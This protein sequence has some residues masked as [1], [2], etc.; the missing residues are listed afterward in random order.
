[1]TEQRAK[2]QKRRPVS[3]IPDDEIDQ[4]LQVAIQ[5]IGKHL[6]G[7]L[8]FLF[9]RCGRSG[10]SDQ[11]VDATAPATEIGPRRGGRDDGT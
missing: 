1:M 2:Q 6:D 11:S 3:E 8:A 9:D 7:F 10:S 5:D 4:E